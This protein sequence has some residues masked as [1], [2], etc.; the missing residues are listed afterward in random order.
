MPVVYLS[1]TFVIKQFIYRTDTL[2]LG[3]FWRSMIMKLVYAGL[4]LV[5]FQLKNTLFQ[6]VFINYLLYSPEF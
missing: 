2:H 3:M 5:S 6:Q 1:Y 4:N